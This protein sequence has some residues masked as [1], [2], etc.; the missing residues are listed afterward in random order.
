MVSKEKGR[1]SFEGGTRNC[2]P[3]G[4]INSKKSNPAAKK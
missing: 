3:R 1:A 4:V 2:D